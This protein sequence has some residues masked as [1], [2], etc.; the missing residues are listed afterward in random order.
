MSGLKSWRERLASP[1]PDAPTGSQDKNPG[2]EV[3]AKYDKKQNADLLRVDFASDS[4]A[5][6]PQNTLPVE[7]EEENLSLKGSCQQSTIDN[8]QDPRSQIPGPAGL[9][10]L[11]LGCRDLTVDIA[12]CLHHRSQADAGVLWAAHAPE[13]NAP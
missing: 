8:R 1:L 6:S 2:T 9:A 7:K 12:F 10:C 11:I 13:G 4:S 3:V 5:K